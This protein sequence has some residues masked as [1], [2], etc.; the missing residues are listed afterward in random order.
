MARSDLLLGAG[1]CQHVPSPPAAALQYGA[2][3]ALVEL[4]PE[5]TALWRQRVEQRGQQER[6]TADEHKPSSWADVQA[7]MARGGGVED[8]SVLAEVPLRC[9]LDS[10]AGSTEQHVGQVLRMLQAAGSSSDG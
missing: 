5:N 6:G 9:R 4:E 8:W 2:L 1:P 10:T 7:V 3:T